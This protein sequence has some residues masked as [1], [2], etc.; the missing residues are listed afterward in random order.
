MS[1]LG[2]NGLKN[3][4]KDFNVI[5]PEKEGRIKCGSYELSLG[6]E[7]FQTDS[8][9]GKRDILKEES[10]KAG[11]ALFPTVKFKGDADSLLMAYWF[12][13]YKL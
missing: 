2:S 13:N 6:G 1:Y 5:S 4:I 3:L 9:S 12:K 8:K 7:V 10:A 11:K